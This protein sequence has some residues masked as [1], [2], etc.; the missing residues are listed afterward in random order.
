MAGEADAVAGEAAA[1]AGGAVAPGG[2][3]PH[4]VAGHGRGGD[5]DCP[6]PRLGGGSQAERG[7]SSSF[8]TPPLASCPWLAAY[9]HIGDEGQKWDLLMDVACRRGTGARSRHGSQKP[10]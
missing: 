6:V 10:F 4:S 7:C 5:D 1:V 2:V 9:H 8:P 3:D